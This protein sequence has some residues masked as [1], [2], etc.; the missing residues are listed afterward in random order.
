MI[1]SNYRKTIDLDFILHSPC[2]SFRDK[3]HL[4]QLTGNSPRFR[5]SSLYSS[6]WSSSMDSSS[7]ESSTVTASG[8]M[9]FWKTGK[10]WG[11][12]AGKEKRA[13]VLW[14]NQLW[15]DVSGMSQR[16]MFSNNE[17]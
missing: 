4:Q 7:I 2:V 9:L 17:Y 16:R 11:K 8:L 6:N 14:S 10:S 1:S 13:D 15:F 3:R 12:R 5:N